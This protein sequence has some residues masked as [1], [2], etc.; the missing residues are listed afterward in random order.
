MRIRD[1]ILLVGGVPIAIA[2]VIALTAWLLLNEAERARNGA[3]L[4][5]AVYRDLLVAMTVRDDYVGARSA[6]RSPQADRFMDMAAS[7]QGRLHELGE[8]ARTVAQR[9]K[10]R[11][12]EE[13]LSRYVDRM[14]QY[15]AVT[16]ANDKLIHDMSLRADA[17]VTLSNEA[18]TRQH[19]SNA[20]IV[21]SLT[22]KDQR[23]GRM[24]D[25]EDHAHELR[26]AL[27][28]VQSAA[29]AEAG[30]DD[31]SFALSQLRRASDDLA[32]ALKRDGR[33]AADELVALTRAVESSSGR[34]ADRATEA[35][36][37][38]CDRLLK[39]EITARRALHEEIAQLL[40]YSVQANDNEQATQNIAIATLKLGQETNDALASRDPE[41]AKLKLQKSSE[42]ATAAATLPIS[43]LIQ[44]DMMDAVTQWRERLGTTIDGL[45]R[46]NDMIADMDN[47]AAAMV[48]SA[49]SLNDMFTGDADQLGSF[50]R[51]ILVVGATF[52]LLF[53]SG[54]A[55][56]VARSITNPL[57][58]LQ[59]R[60][61]A[62]AADPLAGQVGEADRRD[63]LGDMARAANFFVMEIGRREKDLRQAKDR[64]EEAL[65]EL[66][67][68]Q[69][70]LIQAEKLASLGQLVAGVAHEI[71]T[72]L[73]IALTT[74]TLLGDEAKDFERALD[75]N[76][77]PRSRL[78]SFLDRMK[79]GSRLLFVNLGRAA[80]LVHSFKQVAVDQVSD[81]CR[82]FEVKIWLEDVIRSLGPL[83]RKTKHEVA[84]DCPPDLRVYTYPGA[85]TQ[86]LTN[87][88]MNAVVHA[89]GEGQAGRISIAVSEQRGDRL[90]LTVQDD[91]K[92]IPTDHLGR[93]FDPFFTTARSRGSTGLGLHIVY[94]LVTNKLQGRIEVASRPGAGTT[95][96]IDLPRSVAGE[97]PISAAALS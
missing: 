35:L 80:D 13:A 32:E 29:S 90:S 34:D 10:V 69:A 72:P 67:Q 37:A 27:W 1:R 75:G 48:A 33:P 73:G 54:A 76:R 2:A 96:R 42:L 40:T 15:I 95:F 18:R 14:R 78:I 71:N 4:A 17:L 24:R 87:L 66:R 21:A 56:L 47:T 44:A 62:L 11:E 85:L 70:D 91:G 63:E 50:I 81:E 83:L 5:G 89:Y 61:L 16:E 84:L 51:S 19:A 12:V 39:V 38:W 59:E 7:V 64:T 23:L 86:V 43:P 26:A 88:V 25:I 6:D 77:L 52:G 28:T 55:F 97:A 94:N 68:T 8:T 3:V 45:R 58:R 46:Q 82:R 20:D 57:R 93:I 60:M 36:L 31:R 9:D 30:R 92:G 79:E 49:R 22:A 53:G 65:A 41:A 74:A